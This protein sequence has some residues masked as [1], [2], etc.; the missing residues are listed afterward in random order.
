MKVEY[1]DVPE[2]VGYRVEFIIP[3]DEVR[4]I[5]RQFPNMRINRV[6][7]LRELYSGL[8]LREAVAIVDAYAMGEERS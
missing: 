4:A 7:A 6:K 5:A 3:I 8:L 1:R 2:V